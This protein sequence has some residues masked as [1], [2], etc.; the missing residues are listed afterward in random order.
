MHAQYLI[1]SLSAQGLLKIFILHTETY[2]E[3]GTHY[4]F[5]RRMSEK[6]NVLDSFQ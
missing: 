1:D 3:V 2:S 5:L 6:E 4:S